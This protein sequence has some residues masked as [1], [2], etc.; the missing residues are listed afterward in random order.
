MVKS[1]AK[2]YPEIKIDDNNDEC[3]NVVEENFFPA[4]VPLL[5]PVYRLEYYNY[6]YNVNVTIYC[7][8]RAS[9]YSD[10]CTILKNMAEH[11]NDTPKEAGVRRKF[12]LENQVKVKILNLI[13]S[14]KDSLD[15]RGVLIRAPFQSVTVE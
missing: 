10:E 15:Y 3:R 13:V 5:L 8:C 7:L 14:I 12:W 9:N 11:C 4:I 2:V 6:Y 1:F